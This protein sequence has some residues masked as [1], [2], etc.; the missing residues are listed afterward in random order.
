MVS[1]FGG[2]A[3]RRL[4]LIRGM[5]ELA[6]RDELGEEEAATIHV[7]VDSL[8]IEEEETSNSLRDHPE[9]S[10]TTNWNSS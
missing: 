3:E 10:H 7:S 8:N 6:W 5:A 9:D 2:V 1:A 4:S